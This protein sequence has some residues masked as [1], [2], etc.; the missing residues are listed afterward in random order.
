MNKSMNIL[1]SAIV[2]IFITMFGIMYFIGSMAV[3]DQGVNT[4]GTD[5]EQIYD[6]TRGTVQI[7]I[8]LI[9]WLPIL[10]AAL[11]IIFGGMMLFHAGQ[12]KA[13]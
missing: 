2:I 4:T 7:S 5:Y 13:N 12:G 10:L 6:S 3:L 1:L 9:S 8:S 11:T